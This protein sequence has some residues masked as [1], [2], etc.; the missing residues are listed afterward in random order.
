MKFNKWTSLRVTWAAPPRVTAPP[1]RP[2]EAGGRAGNGGVLASLLPGRT[3]E[4][5]RLALRLL[6]SMNQID[7][8]RAITNAWL[9]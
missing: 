1:A 6:F 4:H 7:L 8:Y 5:P 3:T 2:D 9:C